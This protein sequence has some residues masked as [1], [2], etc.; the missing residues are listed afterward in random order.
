MSDTVANKR[1]VADY[2]EAFSSGDVPKLLAMMDD[3]GDWWVSGSIEGM[4]GIYGK[5]AFGALLQSVK[6]I[7]KEGALEITPSSMVAEGD[8]V[9]V[10]AAC[11]AELTDGRVYANRYHLLFELRGGRVL[12]VK[13]YMD[14]QHA[15]ET[16]F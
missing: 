16:F 7:Y 8:R 1:I 12:H 3:D 9:A 11:H 10:E 2:I 4:S 6:P 15:L 14:T 5:V 13:E